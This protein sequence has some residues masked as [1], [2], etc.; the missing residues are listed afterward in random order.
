[1]TAQLCVAWKWERLMHR[2]LLERHEATE[3]RVT[4]VLLRGSQYMPCFITYL[5]IK[6]LT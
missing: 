2:K 6:K 1:M 3:E 5:K 4:A